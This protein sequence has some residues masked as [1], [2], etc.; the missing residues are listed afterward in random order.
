MRN[1]R[2]KTK[3]YR[4][5]LHEINMEE[6]NSTYSD[7]YKF[8]QIYQSDL[9]AK[10]TDIYENRFEE[11]I[12]KY[13]LDENIARTITRHAI[14]ACNY[15]RSLTDVVNK[16]KF[17]WGA[18]IH[19]ASPL[20]NPC[21]HNAKDPKK[22]VIKYPIFKE[23]TIDSSKFAKIQNWDS[24]ELYFD[25]KDIST[26]CRFL[27]KIHFDQQDGSLRIYAVGSY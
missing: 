3:Y 2:T 25:K 18:K 19:D 24:L 1:C 11:K 21:L 15:R 13:C 9:L 16:I 26:D 8:L 17:D 14:N 4:F 22:L 5:L 6:L 27:N 12:S 20:D 23:V 10:M 7:L